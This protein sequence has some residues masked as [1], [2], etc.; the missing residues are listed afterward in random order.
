MKASMKGTVNSRPLWDLK[1]LGGH[2]GYLTLLK[3]SQKPNRI[4]SP[5]PTTI[6]AITVTSLIFL[7]CKRHQLVVE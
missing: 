6:G 3:V 4:S 7:Y 5:K 1:I 2:S